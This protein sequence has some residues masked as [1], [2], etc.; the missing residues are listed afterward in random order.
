LSAFLATKSVSYLSGAR[1]RVDAVSL[2]VAAGEVTVIIG[3]N[4]AGKSTLL[5]LL[6]GELRPTAGSIF[7]DGEI[8]DAS[9]PSRLA[10]QR[11][12]MTQSVEVAFNFTAL[13]VVRLGVD[14]VGDLSPS[15][16][17]DLLEQSLAAVDALQFASRR[18][19]T[20]SG[21]EQKRV[22]FAR[23]LAQL[24]AGRSVCERQAL[25]LD[26][27]V[28]SLDLRHQL[29]LMDAARSAAMRGAAVLAVLHDLNLA[30][31]YA[32]KIALI[33]RGAVVSFGPPSMVLSTR[34]LSPAFG[35][36]LRVVD[37]LVD[38]PLVL[39]AR[40]LRGSA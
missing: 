20:L 11:A 24:A 4:G 10:C 37:S 28:A 16:R 40:W 31:R 39:P 2:D 25:L 38:E 12:V 1:T 7:L 18:Y 6:S 19:E 14:G 21:G 36:D 34:S 15:R 17:A 22:Q 29:A 33:S 32:E 3:P 5:R 35:V 26:E 30:A 27:P 13:E 23:A 8:L 9:R